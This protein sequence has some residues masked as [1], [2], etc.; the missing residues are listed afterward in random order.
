MAHH[1]SGPGPA[2]EALNCLI[3]D[4]YHDQRCIKDGVLP[5]FLLENSANFRPQCVGSESAP[6]RMGSHL[7]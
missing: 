1:R 3:D 4:L 5:A 2:G 7:R 6:R